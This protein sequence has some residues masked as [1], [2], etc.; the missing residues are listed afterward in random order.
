MRQEKVVIIEP[1]CDLCKFSGK[2]ISRVGLGSDP[3]IFHE[4]K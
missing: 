1:V 3:G 2:D 4:A